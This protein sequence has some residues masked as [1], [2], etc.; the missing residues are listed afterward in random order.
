MNQVKDDQLSMDTHKEVIFL[1]ARH[2]E[3]KAHLKEIE[4]RDYHGA[5]EDQKEE[6]AADHSM[7]SAS[8]WV[9][10]EMIESLQAESD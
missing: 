3:A 10:E 7:C 6:I 4:A 1:E 9:L 2:A 8:I 5:S